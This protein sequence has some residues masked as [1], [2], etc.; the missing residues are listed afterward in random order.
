VLRLRRQPWAAVALALAL[1]AGPSLAVQLN[2]SMGAAYDSNVGNTPSSGT[3]RGSSLE[4]LGGYADYFTPITLYTSLLV[5]GSVDGE[6][7]NEFSKLSNG[8]ATV[9]SRLFYRPSGGFFTPML[10]LWGSGAYAKYGSSLR[11]GAEY[12]GGVYVTEQLT[13]AI[14]A[15]IDGAIS[16]RNS[17]DAAFD[18]TSR[19]VGLNLDWSLP[20]GVTAYG[21]YQFRT[22]DIA[23]TAACGAGGPYGGGG[24]GGGGAGGGGSDDGLGGTGD[25]VYKLHANT[26][27]ATLGANFP[28]GRNLS[29]DLQGQY[30][31]SSSS[32]GIDY[33]RWLTFASLLARF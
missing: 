7:Y 29:F 5:R 16:H 22:G 23:S 21:G 19:S 18:L 25:C 2:G 14:S 32:I 15:R 9:L 12:R 31:A 30:A 20:A 10:A 24:G 11:D 17:K 13:T 3:V 27:V 1:P 28:L 26:R 33:T 8:K 4:T 6:V